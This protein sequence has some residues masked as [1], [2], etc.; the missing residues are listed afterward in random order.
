[1]SDDERPFYVPPEGEGEPTRLTDEEARA[2]ID[3]LL[4]KSSR[5]ALQWALLTLPIVVE[6]MRPSAVVPHTTGM[7]DMMDH[8]RADFAEQKRY[9][10][11]DRHS[12]LF[13]AEALEHNDPRVM[14]IGR[15]ATVNAHVMLT[16]K[17]E[18]EE[19]DM[20]EAKISD[21]DEAGEDR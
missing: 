8:V 17:R 13:L 19:D 11:I 1:M 9:N 12:E 3:A 2:R 15:D 4:A 20:L 5:Y 7:T 14:R 10:V 18:T 6:A 21:E 16:L